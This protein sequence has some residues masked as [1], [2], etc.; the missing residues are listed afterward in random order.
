MMRA[1]EFRARVNDDSTVTLPPEIAAEISREQAVRVILLLS[2]SREGDEW[3]QVTADQ[4][5]KGY[6]DSDAVYDNLSTG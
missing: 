3:G 1:L 6:D 4:F 5:F 2:D